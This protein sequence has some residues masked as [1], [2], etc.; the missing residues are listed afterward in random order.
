M[1][2]GGPLPCDKSGGGPLP[3]DKSDGGLLLG[4]LSGGTPSLTTGAVASSSPAT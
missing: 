4:D 1:S 3:Y 2:G